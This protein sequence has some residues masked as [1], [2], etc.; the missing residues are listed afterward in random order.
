MEG[1]ERVRGIELRRARRTVDGMP[2]IVRAAG[3]SAL[4]RGGGDVS[5]TPP[6]P[7]LRVA[8]HAQHE[9]GRMHPHEVHPWFASTTEVTLTSHHGSVT[10]EIRSGTIAAFAR[11]RRQGYRWFQVD[12]IPI[13]DDLISEHAPLGRK[14]LPCIFQLPRL[15]C[16]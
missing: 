3:R 8:P 13:K 11:A 6:S 7:S 1:D 2:P 10:P 12:A 14:N 5:G 9:G 15:N 16:R 4:E